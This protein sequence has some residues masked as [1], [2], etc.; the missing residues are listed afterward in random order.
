MINDLND[1]MYFALVVEHAGFTSAERA[2]GIP[3][4][5]LSRRIAAL[6][7]ELGVSLLQRSTRRFAI[8]PIGQMV[9]RHA[10]G[11]LSE[12]S[13]AKEVVQRA[14]ADPRGVVRV[15][16]PTGIAQSLLADVITSFGLKYP[17]VRVLMH[18]TNRRVDLINDAQDVA[19]RVRNKI[20]E[21][22]NLAT[23]TYGQ[24][25]ELL[26]AS[27][28]YLNVH[29]RPETPEDLAKHTI[30]TAI[31]DEHRM[32][33]QLQ[34]DAGDTR[35]IEF[36]PHVSANDFMLMRQLAVQGQGIT[37]V[38]EIL[39]GSL[40]SQGVLEHVLP[41]WHLPFGILHAVYPARRSLLPAVRA[42]MDHLAEA[43]PVARQNA[44]V[45]S[46]VGRG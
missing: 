25:G 13:A 29:G 41:D 18:I 23:E 14:S 46:P 34:N 2:S 30:M 7:E 21:D 33:W 39:C 10:Q 38:P 8:T 12:V 40:I 5:R 4:S 36:E 6:E 32:R 31:E 20:D 35:R 45:Q 16:A 24:I 37:M 28:A 42:F 9:Y 19:I 11:M 22:A 27:P 3:K 15:S 17:D 26:V 43:M 1:L 44:R